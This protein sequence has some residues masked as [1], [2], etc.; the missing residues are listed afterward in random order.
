MKHVASGVQR[1]PKKDVPVLDSYAI[2]SSTCNLREASANMLLYITTAR[3]AAK[4][5]TCVKDWRF[6]PLHDT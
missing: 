2:C 1:R 3:S 5:Y 4:K 6:A